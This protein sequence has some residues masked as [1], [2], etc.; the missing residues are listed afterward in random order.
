MLNTAK[1][2]VGL[3]GQGQIKK[4]FVVIENNFKTKEKF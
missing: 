1:A 2:I 4:T 3:K